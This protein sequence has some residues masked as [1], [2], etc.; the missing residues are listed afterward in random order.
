MPDMGAFGAGFGGGG[1]GAE[2]EA[3]GRRRREELKASIRLVGEVDPMSVEVE[4]RGAEEDG[5]VDSGDAGRDYRGWSR[6]V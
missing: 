4:E 1:G 5:M 2:T 3:G 6:R